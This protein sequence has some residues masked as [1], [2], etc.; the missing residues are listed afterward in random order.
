M[1]QLVRIMLSGSACDQL[2]W[3]PVLDLFASHT[4]KSAN[5]KHDITTE[6]PL[7]HALSRQSRSSSLKHGVVLHAESNAGTRVV[8]DR[9]VL[10]L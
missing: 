5:A 7:C 10:W 4:Q 9:T 1:L 2:F 8:R 6:G 3:S